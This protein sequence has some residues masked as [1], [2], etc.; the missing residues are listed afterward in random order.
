[1]GRRCVQLLLRQDCLIRASCDR[2][3]QRNQR[4]GRGDRKQH[5][6]KRDD[7]DWPPNMA[8]KCPGQRYSDDGHAQGENGYDRQPADKVIAAE[9]QQAGGEIDEA[10]EPKD[11]QRA[12]AHRQRE[13]EH[14]ES[15]PMSQ[16]TI[17][18]IAG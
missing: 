16:P 2:A 1:M 3:N 10:D 4:E 12:I 5:P 7:I 15:V 14:V 18:D 13:G 17:A 8:G 6:L 9:Q 11:L